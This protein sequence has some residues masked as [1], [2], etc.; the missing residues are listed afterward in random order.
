MT[1]EV[2][3]SSDGPVETVSLV[4]LPEDEH[5]LQVSLSAHIALGYELDGRVYTLAPNTGGIFLLRK[6]SR[7]APEVV[8]EV[9]PAEP[10][11]AAL[12][13]AE[14]AGLDLSLVTGSGSGGRIGIGDVRDFIAS[15]EGEDGEEEDEEEEDVSDSEEIEEAEELESAVDEPLPFEEEDELPEDGE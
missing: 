6:L 9:E 7:P 10:T 11:K 5:D 13:L 1:V 2:T 14:E 8:A 12:E 4:C 15:L 3:I